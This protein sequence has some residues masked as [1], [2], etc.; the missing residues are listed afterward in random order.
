M[1]S[2]RSTSDLHA[3]AP[4]SAAFVNAMREV[5]GEVRVL[6]VKENDVLLGEPQPHGAPCFH[7]GGNDECS[8]DGSGV[9]VRN[10]KDRA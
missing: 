7:V 4:Q 5:F 6:Y 8:S 10:R 1:K 2:A 9:S 3:A